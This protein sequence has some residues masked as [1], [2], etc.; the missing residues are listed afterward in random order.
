MLLGKSV[1]HVN[2]KEGT[3][4]SKTEIRGYY[5]DLTEKVSRFGRDDNKVPTTIVDN[6]EEVYFSI[7]IFQYGL[8]AYDLYL[9]SGDNNMLEK[10]ISCA[11][12]A[13]ENQQKDGGW[14]T[15]A[16]ENS[17]NPYSSMAQGEGISLLLRAHI[18][19]GEYKYLKAADLAKD[20]MLLPVDLG[21]TTRY[22]GEDIYLYEYTHEPL[23][24]N[25]WIFS[26]WG[27]LVLEYK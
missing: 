16:F 2:Q 5:N 1:Y 21:G 13:V 10:A 26:I 17:K 7:A 22:V 12:W 14:C 27:L 15:F 11:D 20:F 8:G 6:G 24:L 4:Y 9:K 3:I 19:T 23:I 25:G 18:S